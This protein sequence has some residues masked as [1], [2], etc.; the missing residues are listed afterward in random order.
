[1]EAPEAGD[2]DS[3]TSKTWRGGCIRTAGGINAPFGLPQEQTRCILDIACVARTVKV[4][5]VGCD[6]TYAQTKYKAGED[7]PQRWLLSVSITNHKSP[8]GLLTVSMRP[9]PSDIGCSVC[10]AASARTQR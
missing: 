3:G 1:M 7:I 2:T 4:R 9:E 6:V 8:K 5:P 10:E